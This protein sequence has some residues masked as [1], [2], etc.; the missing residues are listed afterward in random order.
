[1]RGRVLVTDHNWFEFLSRQTDL[2][3]VNFWQPA[4]PRP[5][6]QLKPGDPVF[7]KHHKEDGGAIAGLGFFANFTACQVWL[8]WE[9]FGEKNGAPDFLTF[10]RMIGTRHKK[11]GVSGGPVEDHEIGCIMLSGPVFF[12]P[13][14]LVEGPNDWA[15]PIVTGKYY[16]LEEG[17]GKRI[18]RECE[19]RLKLRYQAADRPRQLNFP[20][21]RYGDP[22]LGRRRLGQG[23]FRLFIFF[24][25]LVRDFVCGDR[26]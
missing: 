4:G 7:F 8:A 2:D 25:C 11:L 15:D 20:E 5:L 3:E 18:W 6:K 19:E 10:C 16:D 9:A 13:G 22:I 23:I 26:D 12:G 17:E 21:E 1:M 24:Q 14:Q